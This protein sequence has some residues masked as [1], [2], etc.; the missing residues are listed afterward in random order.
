M[1]SL[2]FAARSVAALSPSF[3]ANFYIVAATVIPV[4][5]LAIAVQGRPYES[6]MTAFSH[7]FRRW[8]VPGRWIRSVPAAVIGVTAAVAA[9]GML[10]SAVAEVLAVYAL[11]Q[12]Q[13][14]SATAQNVLLAVTFMV[15]MTAAAP[16]LAFYRVV[17]VPLARG[18]KW[19]FSVQGDAEAAPRAAKAQGAD[20]ESTPP[21]EEAEMGNMGLEN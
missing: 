12:Q 21:D 6:L 15:I 1:I 9:G 2:A 7:A 11:Y 14:R 10:Y 13:A 5:F 16:G 3:N 17:V 20:A 4:L 8:M 18:S 19:I